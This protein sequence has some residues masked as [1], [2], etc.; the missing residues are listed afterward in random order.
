MKYSNFSAGPAENCWRELYVAALFEN[1]KSKLAQR[2][3]EARMAI[4]ARRQKSL[5]SATNTK[6]RHALDSALFCL[7][8]LSGCL[9]TSSRVVA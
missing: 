7:H 8:A 5:T 9:S 6:E 4:V 3:R 2:I 1:D